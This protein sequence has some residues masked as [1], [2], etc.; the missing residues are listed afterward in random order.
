VQTNFTL[1][2]TLPITALRK[3][4]AT[5]FILQFS[6]DRQLRL[7]AAAKAMHKKQGFSLST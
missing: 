3:T 2:G 6:E 4:N 1:S 5:K 7:A